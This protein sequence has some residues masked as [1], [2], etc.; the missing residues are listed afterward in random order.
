MNDGGDYKIYQ[1]KKNKINLNDH[2]L[3][4]LANNSGH[5]M[6]QIGFQIYANSVAR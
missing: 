5:A 6:T 2:F 3:I 4:I 1:D